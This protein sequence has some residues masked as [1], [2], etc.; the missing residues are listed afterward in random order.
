MLTEA[1]ETL[2]QSSPGYP[3]FFK[4]QNDWVE[5]NVNGRYTYYWCFYYLQWS[6]RPTKK[7]VHLQAVVKAG[8]SNSW[9]IVR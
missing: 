5:K 1:M 9:L 7:I 6:I 8:I 4:G 2:A 3:I